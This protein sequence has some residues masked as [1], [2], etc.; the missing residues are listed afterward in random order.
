MDITGIEEYLCSYTS[1]QCCISN[2]TLTLAASRDRQSN[3]MHEGTCLPTHPNNLKSDTGR[4]ETFTH[5]HTNTPAS[6]G[7]FFKEGV[8][9]GTLQPGDL[10]MSARLFYEVQ[11]LKGL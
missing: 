7:T 6:P 10:A 1:L 2:P 9:T 4:A 11:S 5:I 3:T 8:H